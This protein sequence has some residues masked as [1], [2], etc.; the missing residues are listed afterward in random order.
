MKSEKT[1]D[2]SIIN[3]KEYDNIIY[4]SKKVKN[5]ILYLLQVHDFIVES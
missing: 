5:S 2:L 3:N 4:Y 1:G